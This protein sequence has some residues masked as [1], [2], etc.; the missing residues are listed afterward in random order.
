MEQG[1]FR[2]FSPMPFPGMPFDP[3]F[4][5]RSRPN[6]QQIGALHGVYNPGRGPQ[7]HQ[8]LLSQEDKRAVS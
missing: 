5:R 4:S 2:A 8:P 3:I 7:M 6:S 1:V